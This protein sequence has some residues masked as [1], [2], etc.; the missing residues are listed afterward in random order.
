MRANL[1]T[2]HDSRKSFGG[3]AILSDELK[4]GTISLISYNTVVAELKDN[5]VKIYG[6][7]SATTGRHI[8][9]FLLQNGFPK[10]TKALMTKEPILNRT[11]KNL[12]MYS[13]LTIE[14]LKQLDK[15]IDI[16][17][18]PLL[19]SLESGEVKEVT[20]DVK[21]RR[22]LEDTPEYE[23][24]VIDFLDNEVLQALWSNETNELIFDVI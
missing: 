19:E 20:K 14:Q 18:I 16:I 13:T 8:N 11:L 17:D 9:E 24:V 4:K 22:Y 21:I 3:K 5:K 10:I 12:F 1:S 2:I 6:Y 15:A 7:Y 23:V